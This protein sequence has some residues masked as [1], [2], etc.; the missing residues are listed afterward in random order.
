[1]AKQRKATF[2]AT[3]TFW[4]PLAQH[5]DDLIRVYDGGYVAVD[6]VNLRT[7]GVH[8]N[9]YDVCGDNSAGVQP[10]ADARTDAVIHIVSILSPALHRQ[11]GLERGDIQRSAHDARSLGRA[12]WCRRSSTAFPDI[13]DEPCE[14]GS[15]NCRG[16]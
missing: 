12:C 10:D 1:M 9:G 16:N 8:V 4:E 11:A 13:P 5:F 15:R 6:D 3:A 14:S 7:S 2:T